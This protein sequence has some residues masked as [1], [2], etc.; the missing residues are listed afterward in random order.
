MTGAV[1]ATPY[2]VRSCMCFNINRYLF[3]E[4]RFKRYLRNNCVPVAFISG[5]QDLSLAQGLYRDVQKS[6]F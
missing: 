1:Y 4:M 2:H 5:I 6:L 3:E